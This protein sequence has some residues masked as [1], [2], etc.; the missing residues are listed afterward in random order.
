[1]LNGK[2]LLSKTDI[3]N[4]PQKCLLTLRSQDDKSFYKYLTT[5]G[6]TFTKIFVTVI[7]GW[8]ESKNN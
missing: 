1:M 5:Y 7:K 6:C 8:H 3:Q 2:H 4:F